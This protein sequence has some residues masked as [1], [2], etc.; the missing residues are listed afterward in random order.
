VSGAALGK[1]VG[2]AL[3]SFL[4]MLHRE[5]KRGNGRRVEVGVQGLAI[6]RARA[7]R[8]RAV[9]AKDGGVHISES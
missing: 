2:R 7:S 4:V 5:K 6:Y 3:N 9:H 1:Q 8:W